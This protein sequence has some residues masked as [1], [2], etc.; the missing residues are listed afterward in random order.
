MFA[1]LTAALL[2]LG[3]SIQPSFASLLYAASALPV[4]IVALGRGNAASLAAIVSAAVISAVA[5]SP[6]F[7]A[8]MAVF[9]LLPAGWLGHLASL[10]RP[11][12]EIGGPDDQI[13]WY[14]L[15]DMMM[16]L[17]GLVSIGVVLLG[18]MIGYGPDFVAEIVKA[19]ADVA[20]TEDAKLM[21]DP[22][23]LEQLKGMLLV[24]L[25]A[26]QG[27]TWVMMLTA[28]YYIA[29]RI[30]SSSGHAKRPRESMPAALR[31]NRQ[32]LVVFM[33]GIIAAFL[34]GP[35]GLVGA[36]LCGTFSAGFL[37]AGFASLH[38]RTMGKDWRLPALIIVY[39]SVLFV[40]PVF[41]ILILGLAD[42]RRTVALTP[43][44]KGG[45]GPN[46]PKPDTDN[47]HER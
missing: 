46:E 44:R 17:C 7:A 10:A 30:V 12:T 26:A 14:P 18:F 32:S 25:P 28:A 38:Y 4:L 40:L 19:V 11:A 13:A 22:V 21:T 5:I 15:S 3:A 23:S 6:V 41:A 2:A 8:G 36:V 24:L 43:V 37:I 34:N 1:G 27:A 31:M 35:V 16:H 42:T 45:T 20:S 47:E 29:T 33:A 9:T 39:L